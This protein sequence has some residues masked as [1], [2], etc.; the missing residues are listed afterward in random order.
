MRTSIVARFWR[1]SCYRITCVPGV[2]VTPNLSVCADTVFLELPF[3][4]RV[5]AIRDAGFAVEFWQW[6]DRPIQEMAA[7]PGV[8]WT[9]F[10]GWIGGTALHPD[11]VQ[12]FLDGVRRSLE[13]ADRLGCARLILVTGELDDRARPV[14]PPASNPITRWATAY[15]AYSEAAEL[16]AKAAVTYC[17]EN[18]NTKVDHPGYELPT[19]ADTAAI[20]DAVG[21]PNLRLLLDVYHAQIE[22]GN[23]VGLIEQYANRIGLVQVADVPGRHEPGTGELN[24]PRIA[25]ALREAG[26]RGP[27]GLEAFPEGDSNVALRR[28]RDAFN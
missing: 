14:H 27:I 23:V 5:R 2:D 25:A 3:L 17:L 10:V 16:A 22:E 12:D 21:S 18:L 1:I 7:I 20:V 9:S 28:F 26:Y 15:R 13:V 11:G 8:R 19:V 4:D 6:L 24:Y